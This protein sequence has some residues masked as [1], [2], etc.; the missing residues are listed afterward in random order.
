M[1]VAIAAAPALVLVPDLQGTRSDCFDRAAF[2]EVVAKLPP[3]PTEPDA[4]ERVDV[5]DKIGSCGVLSSYGVKGGYIFYA[6]DSPGFD[7]S[8]WGYF[9]DGPDSDLG[10]GSWEGP[11]FEQI[12]GPWYRWTAS[13]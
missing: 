12:E 9:P 7:D 11:Q 2:D 10:N 8:G 13:W 4:F 5:P 1:L 3:P 6:E